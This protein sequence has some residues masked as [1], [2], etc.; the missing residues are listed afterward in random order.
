MATLFFTARQYVELNTLLHRPDLRHL[1]Q[2]ALVTSTKEGIG[3]YR[4]KWRDVK[5]APKSHE[6]PFTQAGRQ[7]LL[8]GY[9]ERGVINLFGALLPNA[10]VPE[11]MKCGAK[12]SGVEFDLG[13]WLGINRGPSQ[14]SDIS[15]D[16]T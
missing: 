5:G 11:C 15:S 2:T 3:Q 4:C 8:C 13:G 14:Q 1:I 9:C 10:R 12:V 16:V 6:S 7:I